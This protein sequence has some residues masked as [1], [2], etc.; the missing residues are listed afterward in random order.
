M[1]SPSKRKQRRDS[2]AK[3]GKHVRT[4][5]GAPR[6]GRDIIWP[7]GLQ[8]RLGIKQCTRWLWEKK[9]KLPPRDV[10]IGGVPV[11]WKPATIEAALR[12]PAAAA[13]GATA[14]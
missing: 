1:G 8:E 3:R 11:G 7:T 6:E 4:R 14:A 9:G 13:E 5:I 10:Y 12:G 2:K